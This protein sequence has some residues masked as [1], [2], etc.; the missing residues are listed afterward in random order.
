MK[1]LYIECHMGIAGDMLLAALYDLLEDKQAY[2]RDLYAMGLPGV[3]FLFEEKML[4]GMKGMRARVIID[5]IEEESFDVD[6]SHKHHHH[7]EEHEH[8]KHHHHHEHN[9]YVS[10]CDQISKLH[11]PLKVKEDA[12][13]IYEIIAK[14]ESQVHGIAVENIHFHELGELD[15]IAD[16]C[17]VCLALYYL[18]V[19]DIKASAIHTGGGMVRIAHGIVPVPAPATALILL[20]MPSYETDIKAE[21][22]T[23]TGAAIL[24]H[25][26]K[27]FGNRPLKNIR[28]I[29]YGFGKKEFDKL[30][31]VRV[32]LLEDAHLEN[33]HVEDDHLESDTLLED[34]IYEI[35]TNIDD[36]SPEVLGYILENVL[37]AGALDV[38]FTPIYMKKNRPAYQLSCM[39]EEGDLERIS[40]LIL[41]NTTSIGL[42]YQKL[43]RFKLRR[44][45]IILETSFGNIRAKISHIGK[46]KKMKPEFVD[47]VKAQ[48]ES[49]QSLDN[50]YHE[51]Y[52]IWDGLS[53]D[54]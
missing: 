4:K 3:E 11:L 43:H 47:V 38:Y 25:F 40:T 35:H 46:E 21:L 39:V 54:R 12:M 49:E 7:H 9:S 36:M 8:S 33:A 48:R 37:E 22:C 13:A 5:G 50:I 31:A 16:I 53:W 14:A 51:I 10:I 29:S 17:G 27:G 28:K 32:F 19:H 45:E 44:E 23:P 26:A 34:S 52:R 41:K 24:K 18:D 20:D 6:H 1:S 2:K 30:N 42:R 15:A